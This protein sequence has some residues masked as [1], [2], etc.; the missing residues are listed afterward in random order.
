MALQLNDG[1]FEQEVV[2]SDTPV[3]VD[4]FAP[5]CGPCKAVGPVID[6]LATEYEGRVKVA[7][8]N[9]DES[10]GVAQRFGIRSIPTII[11]FSGGQVKQTV[12]GAVPKPAL[13]KVLDDLIQ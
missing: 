6:Q 10:P 1:N 13:V 5:W 7:K 12:T 9:V 2:L 8:V 3:L 4:F 11:A